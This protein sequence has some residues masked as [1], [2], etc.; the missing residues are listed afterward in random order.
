MT[1]RTTKTADNAGGAPETLI[2]NQ[3][4]ACP[5][6][7]GSGRGKSGKSLCRTCRGVG[8]LMLVRTV[9]RPQT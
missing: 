3:P 1:K 4:V 6:C 7:V 8:L 9:K 5:D 2:L